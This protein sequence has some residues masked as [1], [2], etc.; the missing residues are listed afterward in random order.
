MAKEEALGWH[1]AE[2]AGVGVFVFV[3]GWADGERV[4]GAAALVLL[5]DV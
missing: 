4:C 5:V 2:H 3:F 1:G